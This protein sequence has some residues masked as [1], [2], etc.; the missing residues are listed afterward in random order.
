MPQL[1]KLVS[2]AVLCAALVGTPSALPRTTGVSAARAS[3]VQRGKKAK[4]RVQPGRNLLGRRRL[5]TFRLVWQTVRDEHF[6]PTFGGVDWDAVRA[7]YAPRAARAKSD[8][9][10]HRL[11][12]E[13]LN[14][15]HQSHFAIVPPESI[16][17]FDARRWGALRAEG[18]SA[19]EMSGEESE[20]AGEEVGSEELSV[21]MMNG[22]GV[23]VR[24]LDGRL[25]ITRVAP[26]G[27]AARAG[28]RPGFLLSSVDDDP[29]EEY[30]K[31]ALSDSPAKPLTLVRI[32]EEILH[33]Y[34]GGAPGSEVRLSYVDEENRVRQAVVKRE[35]LGGE[36]SPPLGSLP[37]MYTEIESRRLPGEIGYVRFSAFT[38]QLMERICASLRA[39][40]DARGIVLDLRGNPGGVMGMASGVVGLITTQPGLLGAMRTRTGMM[41]L[42]SFPQKSPY[43]GPVVV[44]IDALSGSTAEV[45]AAALQES[46]RAEVVGERSAGMVLGADTR[47]LPT[48]ALLLYARAGFTTS[49][50]VALE[51][52]GVIPDVEKKLDRETLLKGRDEQLEEA[53]RQIQTLKPLGAEGDAAPPPPPR[54]LPA[55]SPTPAAPAQ[56][57]Q[58][59]REGAGKAADAGRAFVSTPEAVQIM[60]RHI[61]A[62]GGRTALAALKSR[63]STGTCTLP[64][65]S[66]TGKVTI[67]EQA[68]NKKSMEINVPS[69]GVMQFAFDGAR[70]WM[71]HPLMGFIEYT[72]QLLPGLQRDSDF[73][74]LVNYREQYVRMEHAGVRGK[75]NVLFLTTPEGTVE[76]ML[77]DVSSG[78]LVY[79]GGMHFDDYRQVGAVK[80]PFSTRFTF[81]GLEML[82]RLEHV[83]HDAPI[84]PDA[85]AETQSCFTKR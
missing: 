83:T 67:Y 71:Q 21:R 22:I 47:R 58:P 8:P 38:P 4:K 54:H 7:R 65:Q 1:F 73:H 25:V 82:I 50:G 16:P 17:R 6:D 2:F 13:M 14:E 59:V 62:V 37:S 64:M 39:L 43:E 20:G 75:T 79:Q 12:Q 5:E 70:G 45:L 42:P 56:G 60:E 48:G 27:P 35:R 44:L 32:R 9:E 68:P 72:E 84:S 41:P 52:R 29:V 40:G 33:D 31:L 77:F 18:E 57:E 63:V 74:K 55:P 23:D 51:G 28:L 76:E 24:V 34:L 53:V 26:N 81:S 36:L 10:L 85:F 30:V 69:M 15:L 19:E 61:E 49:D 3:F 66:M 78:L 80:V 11:L 46:G